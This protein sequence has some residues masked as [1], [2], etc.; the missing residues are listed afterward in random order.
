MPTVWVM[1]ARISSGVSKTSSVGMK[2]REL[3]EVAWPE[4]LRQSRK[5]NDRIEFQGMADPMTFHDVE[6]SFA[7]FN[8]PNEGL[9]TFQFRGRPALG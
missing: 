4:K 9:F 8:A 2:K 5:L 6:P 1:R 3:L 7:F